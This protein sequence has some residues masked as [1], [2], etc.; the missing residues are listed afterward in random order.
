[1]YEAEYVEMLV[2]PAVDSITRGTIKRDFTPVFPALTTGLD[3]SYQVAKRFR[4]GMAF[5]YQKGFTKISAYDIYYNDGN[6]K[7]DQRAKQYGYGDFYAVQLGIRYALK[8]ANGI[9]FRS[10]K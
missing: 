8:D 6:G 3:V 4:I 7:N 10:K 5:A 9:R 1:M 2:Y